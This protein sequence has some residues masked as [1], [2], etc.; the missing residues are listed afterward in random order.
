MSQNIAMLVSGSEGEA[1]E[2]EP[3]SK[4]FGAYPDMRLALSEIELEKLTR[5][6]IYATFY[7]AAAQFLVDTKE[8]LQEAE[9]GFLSIAKEEHARAPKRIDLKSRVITLSKLYA[10]MSQLYLELYPQKNY[11]K[12]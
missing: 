3:L 12:N 6:G 8:A 4:S 10:Q 1:I 7:R 5:Q 11:I 2:T 9:K